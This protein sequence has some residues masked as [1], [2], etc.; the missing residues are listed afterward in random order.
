MVKNETQKIS[1]LFI[2]LYIITVALLALG[3]GIMNI[4]FT[5]S[6]WTTILTPDLVWILRYVLLGM[7]VIAAGVFTALQPIWGVGILLLSTL[8]GDFMVL[9]IADK[10]P[11]LFFRLDL[12]LYTYVPSITF[13]IK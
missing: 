2:T 5:D 13:F 1:P 10:T 4:Y 8:F 11:S 12:F 3:G 6:S 7:V 9:N